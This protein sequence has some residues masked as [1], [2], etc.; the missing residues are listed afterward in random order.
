MPLA[1]LVCLAA[2]L[3]VERLLDPHPLPKR[4]GDKVAAT[5]TLT[6]DWRRPVAAH[7]IHCGV[8]L[9]FFAGSLTICQRPW[10]SA[11][12]TLAFL[13]LVVFV[14]NAKFRAL[15]EPFVFTDFGLFSQALHHPR[16]Y[17]PFLGAGRAIIALL[18]FALTLY[19]G[20]AFEPAL[21]SQLSLVAFASVILISVLGG[22][23][24]MWA[25]T[26]RVPPI[27]L[28]P[29]TDIRCL[30]LVTSLWLYWLAE[31]RH[32]G[33]PQDAGYAA[34]T[35][36]RPRGTHGELPDI[37]VVQSESFFDARC[38]SANIKPDVLKHFDEMMKV[39]SNSGRLLV[40]AWGANTMRT[41]FAFLS[42]LTE[43]QLGVHRFNPYRRFA[44][45]ELP[46]LASHLRLL[47][48]RTVCIHPHPASFF[49]RDRVFPC[50]GFDEFLDIR[51][52]DVSQRCGPYIS[53]AA[54]TQKIGAVLATVKYPTFVFVITMENHGPLHLEQASHGE[55]FYHAAP[56]L[57]FDE[58]TVY[59][60]HLQNA[61]R[62][63]GELRQRLLQQERDSVLCFFGDHVPS[64][65]KVYEVLAFN[66]GRT[67][68]FI[69]SKNGQPGSVADM[70]VEALGWRVLEAV[71]LSVS[72]R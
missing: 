40:P 11:G 72:R 48:Y 9:L 55:R 8:V 36:K 68:F 21:I 71:G 62:M 38:L 41:E 43:E 63:I 2:S 70:S 28:D 57:G 5:F 53:D 52:F 66:D 29:I 23:L 45:R 22:V 31:R 18:L 16:L 56:P 12:L 30:G 60:R 7:A 24:L 34:L 69:W 27:T 26:V 15:R 61:D 20:I 1:L 59:L 50:L 6:P 39:S 10:L 51:E 54:V 3:V 17:L 67:D 46:T 19:S 64:M 47:G 13:T 14:N 44:R 58:L 33:V 4:E 49:G 42:G 25:G 35:I 65:P 37:V 32:P